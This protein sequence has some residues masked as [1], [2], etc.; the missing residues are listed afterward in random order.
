LTACQWTKVEDHYVLEGHMGSAYDGECYD[1]EQA[2]ET[3]I[4]SPDC[5]AISSQ[6]N[7]CGGRYRV[8]H[9]GP[10]LTFYPDA[11]V[12]YTVDRSTC[13]ADCGLL[14]PALA[15]TE[16]ADIT[17]YSVSNTQ[18]DLSVGAFDVTAACASGY[19]S[20]GAGPSAAACTMSGDYALSGC[21][22][23]V[24]PLCYSGANPTVLTGTGSS[25]DECPSCGATIVA[26]TAAFD[27]DPS[28]SWDGCC[29][30]Y[31]NQEISFTLDSADVAVTG[32][33]FST[34]VGEC[35]GA[36][37]L[38]AADGASGPWVT[39]DSQS[40]QGCHVRFFC[41]FHYVS[42]IFLTFSRLIRAGQHLC[43]VP[44]RRPDGQAPLAMVFQP[45]NRRQRQRHTAP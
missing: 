20:A 11:H 15:C 37:I 26:A 35:P 44:A 34:Q 40:E 38:E 28:T 12:S 13:P 8:T 5:R 42:P 32:Y 18:L 25:P 33:E 36:W 1:F 22:S 19:E 16:P 21:V 14:G 29:S 3:C 43:Y 6:S 31:P 39:V 17:G 10:T 23:S 27:S 2:I 41:R 9:G 30:G 4:A 7:V 24:V 45:R